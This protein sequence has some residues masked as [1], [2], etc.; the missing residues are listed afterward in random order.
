M[1][2]V[3]DLQPTIY[4][5]IGMDKIEVIC[6]TCKKEF[7][8]HPYRANT[9][10]FC[11]R[12]C[13]GKSRIGSRNSCWRGGKLERSDGYIFIYKPEHPYTVDNYVM[14]HR[15]VMEEKL[16]RYLK[17]KEKVHHINGIKNDNRL[18]N[19]ELLL[20]QSEHVKRH[21]PNGENWGKDWTGL[22]RS[23]ET[24]IKMSISQK[25]AWEIRKQK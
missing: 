16:G 24:R 8:V 2:P 4:Y 12:S 9:A 7:L 23:K 14:E 21:Y 1:I 25:K 6:E 20:N 13:L 5:N 22:K 19:L 11:S 3:V 18:E 10:R 15:L 17:T